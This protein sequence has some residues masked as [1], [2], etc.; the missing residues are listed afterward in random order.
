MSGGSA[1]YLDASE[2]NGWFDAEEDKCT[3]FRKWM[4]AKIATVKCCDKQYARKEWSQLC[5]ILRAAH[6]N[7]QFVCEM[8]DNHIVIMEESRQ[9]PGQSSTANQAGQH[10]MEVA[11]EAAEEGIFVCALDI[12]LCFCLFCVLTK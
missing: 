7:L 10:P 1:C 2:L 11:K 6:P 12:F 3:V 4:A 8:M 9:D 5:V